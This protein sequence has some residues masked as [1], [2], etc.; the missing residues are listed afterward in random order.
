MIIGKSRKDNDTS[1][2][3]FAIRKLRFKRKYQQQKTWINMGIRGGGGGEE[4]KMK[5]LM[6]CKLDSERSIERKIN[7]FCFIR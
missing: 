1:T 7:K 2:C 5:N 4:T 6:A 3:S